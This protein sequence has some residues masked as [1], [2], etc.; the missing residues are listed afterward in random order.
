MRPKQSCAFHFIASLRKTQ[1]L[2][3]VQVPSNGS[4]EDTPA[5]HVERAEGHTTYN[6]QLTEEMKGS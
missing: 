3:I 4:A 1:G 6:L 2:G 5:D